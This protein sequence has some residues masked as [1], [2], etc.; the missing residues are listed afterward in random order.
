MK[1]IACEEPTNE[2]KTIGIGQ[3][4]RQSIAKS[5]CF[6]PIHKC[7]CMVRTQ[8]F[9]VRPR[10]DLML[11]TTERCWDMHRQL[12][13]RRLGFNEL[14]NYTLVY[15]KCFRSSHLVGL[16]IKG[17]VKSCFVEKFV[18]VKFAVLLSSLHHPVGGL[19][20]FVEIC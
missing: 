14:Y 11:Q 20:G 2:A 8:I 19:I 1:A 15:Q 13:M 10:C 5:R 4:Q 18:C 16:F 9:R 3:A 17:S 12:T 6:V 7:E